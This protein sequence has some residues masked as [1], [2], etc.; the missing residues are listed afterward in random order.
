MRK[1]YV[2]FY[3]EANLVCV[4]LLGI[5]LIHNRLH[6]SQQ[7]KQLWFNRTIISFILYFICDSF[8]SAMLGGVLPGIR[9]LSLLLNLSNFI[10]LGVITYHWFMYM[11][12][13]EQLAFRTSRRKR[14]LLL[15]PL[16]STLLILL[17]GYIRDPYGWLG[18]SGELGPWYSPLQVAAPIFYVLTAFIVSL[19]SIRKTESSSERKTYWLIGLFPLAVMGFGLI[20]VFTQN[21]PTFCFGSTIMTV[22]FYI[23]HMQTLV[24]VDEL[25]RLNNRGQINRHMEQI[26]FRENVQ[27]FVMMIDIDGFKHI[28]DTYG[29]AEG[30]RALMLASDV[31]KQTCDSI[32][33]PAFI[34]RYGGDEFLLIIHDPNKDDGYPDRISTVFRQF[35]SELQQR[36]QLP[37][38][39][40]VS[41]GYDRLRN[42]EDTIQDCLIRADENLYLEKRAKGAGR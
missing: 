25:T 37:Y 4:I 27:V 41:I 14:A 7:E 24:S 34:G 42:R 16:V 3:T 28:N 12:A 31:L 26:R 21:A 1:D 19:H 2:I 36:T 5:L 32:K 9:W 18:E 17:I 29:H 30:D 33:A 15:L 23:Q 35:L 6:S 40:N 39:L 10:L 20:Q 38:A 11:A 13:S 22:F 8:W